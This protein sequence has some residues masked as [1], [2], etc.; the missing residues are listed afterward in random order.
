MSCKHVPI[1]APA[2][3]AGLHELVFCEDFETEMAIDFSGEGREGYS[4]YADR[5]YGMPLLTP[6]ECRVHGSV[7]RLGAKRCESAV[8]L[9]TYS[10][11]GDQGFLMHFGYAEAHIRVDLPVAEIYTCSPTFCGI[12][13]DDVMGRPWNRM[14]ALLAAQMVDPIDKGRHHRVGCD[15][16]YNGVL[17]DQVKTPEGEQRLC[18]NVVNATGYNDEFVYIDDAWHTYGVL[19]EPGHV[20]W[21]V[22]GKE[23]HSVRFI[24]DE[25][26]QYYHR[27]NPRPLPR[28]E[29]SLP[30]YKHIPWEGAHTVTDRETLV[31]F[32]GADRNWPMEVD[33]VR[34]W[35]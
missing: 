23:M 31:L 10:R 27:G 3:Q 35:Q 26:P 34:V 29:D 20:A 12:C 17:I 5:P 11:A 19:W 7:L 24:G 15:V 33:W 9:G 16:I 32:L 4:F 2:V 13:A 21:Y 18:S 1:P 6:T 22:D 14:A 25:L 30:D 28:I 8:G